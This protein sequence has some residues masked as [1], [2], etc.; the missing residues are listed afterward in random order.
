MLLLHCAVACCSVH[1]VLLHH[2]LPLAVDS[3]GAA[4]HQIV[5]GSVAGGRGGAKL[6]GALVGVLVAVA[7]I[8]ASHKRQVHLNPQSN[9]TPRVSPKCRCYANVATSSVLTSRFYCTA[10][11]QQDSGSEMQTAFCVHPLC[12]AVAA[13]AWLGVAGYFLLAGSAC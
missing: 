10:S 3:C 1:P 13:H 6:P 4:Q 5:L 12:T 8:P 2:V 11:M 9:D 7:V